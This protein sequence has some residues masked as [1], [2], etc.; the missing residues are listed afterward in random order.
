[1]ARVGRFWI[2]PV[3]AAL[4]LAAAPG[5][6]AKRRHCPAGA[7]AVGS[8][9]EVR[10]YRGKLEDDSYT[11]SATY[12]ACLRRTGRQMRVAT[13]TADHYSGTEPRLWALRG[14][15]VAVAYKHWNYLLGE[16]TW[17]LFVF[18]VKAR[19]RI[20][21][22]VRGNAPGHVQSV[23]TMALARS[24]S[25]AFITSDIVPGESNTHAVRVLGKAGPAMLDIGTDIDPG[26]LALR[27][28]TV[29]WTRAG[30]DRSAPIR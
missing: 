13:Q 14:H 9:K 12:Y 21:S 26:S 4:A 17:S 3:I 18:D 29:H 30:Q 20:R 24:G 19:R 8:N 15:F 10:V 1:L 7:A 11:R 28:G 16:D 2:A 25:A 22:Q 5:A 23:E 27:G 6:D